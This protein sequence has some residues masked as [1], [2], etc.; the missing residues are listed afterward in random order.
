[1]LTVLDQD[2]QALLNQQLVIEDDKT[3]RQ[4]EYVV[5]I[6]DLEELADASLHGQMDGQT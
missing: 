2:I 1:M 5:A 6:S 4:G 3:A